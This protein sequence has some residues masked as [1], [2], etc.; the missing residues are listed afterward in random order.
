MFRGAELPRLMTGIVMLAVIF[1][2]I[3]RSRDP[4]TWRWLASDADKPPSARRSCRRA[5]RTIRQDPQQ[6]RPDP[7]PPQRGPGTASRTARPPPQAATGPTDEDPDQAEAANE[8]FQAITDGTLELQR[9]EM[10][11]YDRLVAG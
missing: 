7:A 9:E 2:L 8:E 11:P 3:V 5:Q 1:M 10:D 4:D 6:R